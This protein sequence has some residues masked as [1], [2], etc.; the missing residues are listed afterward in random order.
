MPKVEEDSA[1]DVMSSAMSLGNGLAGIPQGF[2][3]AAAAARQSFEAAAARSS[4][5]AAAA[6]RH[7]F[8]A[9]RQFSAAMPMVM[10]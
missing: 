8:D 5:D 4:F 6:A 3:T 1:L 10:Q 2:D 7:S 9:T